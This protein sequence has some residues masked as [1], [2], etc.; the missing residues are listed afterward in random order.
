MRVLLLV[1][2][3]V[4]NFVNDGVEERVGRPGQGSTVLPTPQRVDEV[5][6]LS[7]DKLVRGTGG[8]QPSGYPLGR[9]AGR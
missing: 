8:N 9:R 4:R 6:H 7:V 2:A 3:K 5:E 1:S